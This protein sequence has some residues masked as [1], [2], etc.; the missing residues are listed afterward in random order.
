MNHFF[1]LPPQGNHR[2]N[3]TPAT[4]LFSDLLRMTRNYGGFFPF[5]G[6]RS[7]DGHAISDH[8]ADV[9]KMVD[10][11]S[12]IQREVDHLMVTRYACRRKKKI[13][14]LIVFPTS[15]KR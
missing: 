8:F 6:H 1:Y 9:S 3:N 13:A 2:R 14:Y 5:Q 11:G 10:I 4:P 12:G 15:G 7:C